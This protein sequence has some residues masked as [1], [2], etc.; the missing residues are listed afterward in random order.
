[1]SVAQHR[2]PHLTATRSVLRGAP[3]FHDCYSR[4]AHRW[5]SE[6]PREEAAV[7]C[8]RSVIVCGSLSEFV[9]E[10]GVN[11]DQFRSFELYRRHLFSPDVVT[12][13][14]LYERAKLIV[15]STD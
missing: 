13:D 1:M 3:R 6:N 15:E 9:K 7:A 10:F 12:F 5:P 2:R 4:Q 8:P 14:E 11:E